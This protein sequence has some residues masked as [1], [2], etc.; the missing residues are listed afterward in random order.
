MTQSS[1]IAPHGGTLVDRVPQ[2]R[3][4]DILVA[5]AEVLPAVTL[6]PWEL[7]DLEMI[8]IGALSPLTGFMGRLDYEST[9]ADMRLASGLPWT[10]PITLRVEQMPKGDHIALRDGDGQLAGV[11]ELSGAFVAD[12]EREA[13][14]V[15]GTTD[16]AHP[17]VQ[18]LLGSG[19]L[20]LSG[21]VWL[22]RAPLSAFPDLALRPADTRREFDARG[23]RRIVGFQTRNPVHRAHEYIQK[24]ALEMVDGL[25]LHPLVGTTKGDDVPASVRVRSY[26]VLLEHYYPA[27]RVLL[28]AFPAAM[29]YAG[30]REAVFHAIARK[31][32]GCTHFIVGRD[33]AGVGSFYGSYDAQ[34]IFDR[35]DPKELGIEPIRFEHT[36]FCR[37][38]ASMAS[39]KTCPHD[40][41]HH[42]ALSG[43]RV[44][45]LLRAGELPPPEFSRAE[46]ARA[47]V[48]GLREAVA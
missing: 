33:H 27:D 32:Y 37:K 26:R 4:R 45:E 23:W 38:C 40:A 28:A 16:P 35:F 13:S 30:P 8:G 19:E 29:R 48:D 21:D 1:L 7:A 43:T 14:L 9:L 11:L 10:M 15:Y 31:N 46:V 47:L 12:R 34:H 44:R 2:G 25:L 3:A 20:A 24:A 41:A 36:F 18:R 22:T 5:Q 17:G 42:V 39:P 6:Q